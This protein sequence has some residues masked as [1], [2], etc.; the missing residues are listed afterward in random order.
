MALLEVKNLVVHYGK[1][2]ALD[3]VTLDV[4]PGDLVAVLG[5]IRRASCRESL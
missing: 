3:G 1:A 4:R 2:L 5:Q